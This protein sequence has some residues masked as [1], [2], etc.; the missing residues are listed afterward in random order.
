MDGGAARREGGGG[1]RSEAVS[2]L[3]PSSEVRALHALVFFLLEPERSLH[4]R[5]R[6][7]DS[8]ELRRE[9]WHHVLSGESSTRLELR[10]VYEL[11]GDH[12]ERRRDQRKDLVAVVRGREDALHVS[13]GALALRLDARSV[14]NIGVRK[15]GQQLG[16][17]VFN[18]SSR[19]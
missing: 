7:I 6:H 9:L 5:V 19:F 18:G 15:R 16:L 12:L 3:P 2:N 11:G 10:G 13:A 1:A 8:G 14:L 17:T 4:R